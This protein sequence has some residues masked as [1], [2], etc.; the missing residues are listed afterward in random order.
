MVCES[1]PS[2]SFVL[3]NTDELQDKIVE[4]TSRAKILEEALAKSHSVVSP[5]PH[6]LLSDDL[7]QIKRPI[8]EE[9]PEPSLPTSNPEKEEKEQ[10]EDETLIVYNSALGS[11]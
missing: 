6:P 2:P 7:L 8:K 11:L 10:E 3:A 4:L 9:S 5:Q 1:L